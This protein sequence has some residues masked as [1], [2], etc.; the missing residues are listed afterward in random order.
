MAQLL[1]SQL[2]C[3]LIL[4]RWELANMVAKTSVAVRRHAGPRARGCQ[5]LGGSG[6]E[7]LGAVASSIGKT[8]TASLHSPKR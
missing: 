5:H 7:R 4:L 1:T 2:P 8:V 3:H 6:W